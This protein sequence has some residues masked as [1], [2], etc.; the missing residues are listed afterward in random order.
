MAN[1]QERRN[2][3]G[4]LISYSIRVHRGRGI[5]GKQLKPYTATF[6]VEPTWS[7]KTA[8]KKAEAFASTFERDCKEGLV[9][10]NRQTFQEYAE[11]CINLKEE[12]GCK[13][14]TI[15]SYREKTKR[16]YEAL[17]YLKLK[18]I[19]PEHLSKFYSS[20]MKDGQNARGGKLSVKTI[21]GY[22]RFISMVLE[23]AVK[24]G[25]LLYAPSSRVELP[26]C[27]KHTPNYFQP[28]Q[29]EQI[30]EAL[31]NE[32]MK[33]KTMLHLFMITGARRGEILGLK[34]SDIDFTNKTVRF[35]RAVYYRSDCG[36]YID[37][38]K[39]EKSN[40][41]ISIP[42]YTIQLLT[43]YKNYQNG[44]IKSLK[45][46]YHDEGFLFTQDNGK[47]MNPDSVTTYCDK[48][49]K[50]HNL[51]HINPHAFRHTSASLL[52]FGGL[53]SVTISKRLGHSQVSTT[54]DIYAHVI[55]EAERKSADVL[56]DMIFKQKEA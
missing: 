35:S 30:Q 12:R 40:R 45:E 34:W 49:S 17:G 15:V 27:E 28:E 19:R 4:K 11:Y 6:E 14:S 52:Y 20:M 41:C 43:F 18:D 21:L 25:I 26:K 8:R 48:F 39:T 1:I 23:Q 3:D 7:E 33:W 22:H 44:Y 10:D 9:S 55:E 53:D 50:A 31:E 56:A 5:D 47:P 38:L 51:P 2:K 37:S 36:I 42:D 24:E 32:P 54:S 46:Y 16:V 29:I 13:H